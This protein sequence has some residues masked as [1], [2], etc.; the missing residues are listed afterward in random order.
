MRV[1]LKSGIQVDG[2]LLVTVWDARTPEL[3][4]LAREDR[5]QILKRYKLRNLVVTSGLNLI[6]DLLAQVPTTGPTH[7]AFG[8]SNTAAASGQTALVAEVQRF[9]LAVPSRANLAVVF[10]YYLG[11]SYMN[12]TTIR[13]AGLFNASNVLVARRVVSPEVP[14]DTDVAVTWAWTLT[15]SAS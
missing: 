4:A 2:E 10:K 3:E 11:T 5:G 8:T 12:G 13:E 9:P 6:R 14:K 1:S 7:I 15:F